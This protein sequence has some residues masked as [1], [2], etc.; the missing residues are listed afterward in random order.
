MSHAPQKTAAPQSAPAPARK[1]LIIDDQ[2]EVLD[3]VEYM[4]SREGYSVIAA[5]SGE[6]GLLQAGLFQPDLILCDIMMPGM[7]GYDVLAALRESSDL[8]SAPF[9]FLTAKAAPQE[10]REG[11]S[12]GA[13]DYL[14]KPFTADELVSAVRTRLQ[15][16]ETLVDRFEKRMEMLREGISTVLPHE[17][18]TPLTLI[19]AHS[20]LLLEAADDLDREE[21]RSAHAAIHESAVRLYRLIENVLIYTEREGDN[22]LRIERPAPVE[23]APLAEK[24]A[25]KIAAQYERPGDL[26]LRLEPGQAAMHAFHLKKMLEETVDNAFKF[27]S[28]GSPVEVRLYGEGGALRLV[29]TDAGRGMTEAEIENMG[30]YMQFGRSR[31]EQ[32]GTGLG[33]SVVRRLA[34]VYRGAVA[35]ESSPGRGARVE[36]TLPDVWNSPADA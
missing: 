22:A 5:R 9:V 6:E 19:L 36:V 21:V 7:T 17:L 24:T 11:M 20:S 23:A 18:R 25:A 27:S 3:M 8:A 32:Q 2:R 33:L 28:A 31:Y 12:L 15:K 13:D 29:V 14:T 10:L 4:L 30:A 16:R 26:T 1:V 34:R 35:V